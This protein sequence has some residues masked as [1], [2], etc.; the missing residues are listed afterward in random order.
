MYQAPNPQ[1]SPSLFSLITTK[2]ISFSV[3]PFKG[4][5]APLSNLTG[6]RLMYSSK[7]ILI[8]RSKSLKNPKSGVCIEDGEIKDAFEM[9][10]YDHLETKNENEFW[11]V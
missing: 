2:S 8:L 9:E 11:E 3:L 6:L 4:V 1:Y 7:P 10:V 5:L